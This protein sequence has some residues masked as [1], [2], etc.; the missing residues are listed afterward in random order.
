MRK[1]KTLE[2]FLT[3]IIMAGIILISC[4]KFPK[5]EAQK[6]ASKISEIKADNIVSST[7]TDKNGVILLMV[8]NKTK[9]TARIIFNRET[10]ELINQNPGSGVWYKNNNYELRGKGN[11]IELKKDG[12]IVF[13]SN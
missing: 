12:E 6:K 10:I 13:K 1:K 4:D 9:G 5:Q 2:I 7:S 3:I 11:D 8:F